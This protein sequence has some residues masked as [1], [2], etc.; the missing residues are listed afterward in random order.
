MTTEGQNMSATE[1]PAYQD[2]CGEETIE[3]FR[4]RTYNGKIR[5]LLPPWTPAQWFAVIHRE[6]EWL[7]TCCGQ[8]SA[9]RD[10]LISAIP[11][12]GWIDS[13]PFMELL[14]TL[15]SH[16]GFEDLLSNPQVYV[17]K[18]P[19]DPLG[20]L[21]LVWP[22]VR[23]RLADREPPP[24]SN[25]PLTVRE[26]WSTLSR[27]STAMWYVSAFSRDDNPEAAASD[28]LFCDMCISRV[29]P[30]L[31]VLWKD[32][33]NYFANGPITALAAVRDE[34]PEEILNLR[35]GPAIFKD[36]AHLKDTASIWCKSDPEAIK[37][38]G[39]RELTL[40][41]EGPKLVG[42]VHPLP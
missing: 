8:I 30:A 33:P 40:S 5:S 12:G 3:G 6:G 16:D 24:V 42:P 32:L 27:I 23:E 34:S 21:G 19:N 22:H 37:G 15:S 13:R 18:S 7:G 10:I 41:A 26:A 20:Q 9:A 36:V 11:D 31:S 28:K 25:G 14:G 38:I 4:C 17:E 29:L 35:R 1:A 2:P 39:Y